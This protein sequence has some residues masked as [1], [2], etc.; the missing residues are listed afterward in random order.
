MVALWM[1]WTQCIHYLLKVLCS[2]R[3]WPTFFYC[4]N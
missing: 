1:E 4:R 3:P 2:K